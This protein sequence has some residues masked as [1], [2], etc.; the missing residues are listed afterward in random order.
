[1]KKIQVSIV[2]DADN[3]TDVTDGL[4]EGFNSLAL[5]YG[6]IVDWSYNESGRKIESVPIQVS[7]YTEGQA[8]T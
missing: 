5:E 2:V 4:N 8:W 7:D 3:D 1:M 6:F